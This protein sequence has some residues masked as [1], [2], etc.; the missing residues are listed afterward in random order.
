M[1]KKIIGRVDISK[2]LYSRLSGVLPHRTLYRCICIIIDQVTNDLAEN[3]VVTVR[4]FGTLSPFFRSGHTS[5]DVSQHR[6]RYSEGF[7][8]VSFH[9]HESFRTLI[10]ERER[11]FRNIQVKV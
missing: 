9:P 10:R 1:E 11:N 7:F 5:Y 3:H 8:T 2:R 6:V 4:R